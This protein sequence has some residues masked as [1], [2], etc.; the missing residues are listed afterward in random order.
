MELQN[1]EKKSKTIRII[2]F[3][4]STTTTNILSTTTTTAQVAFCNINIV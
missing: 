4:L 3:I 2:R 1:S